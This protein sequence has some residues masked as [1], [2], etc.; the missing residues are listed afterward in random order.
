MGGGMK[1]YT[2]SKGLMVNNC[3]KTLFTVQDKGVQERE[4]IVLLNLKKELYVPTNIIHGDK[5]IFKIENVGINKTESIFNI[6][7]S[8]ERLK[9][10]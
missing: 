4:K 9:L 10:C 8:K 3:C 6:T 1:C 7:H 5:N 2:D